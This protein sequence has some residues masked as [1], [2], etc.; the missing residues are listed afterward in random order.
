MIE[1]I[2]DFRAVSSPFF[3]HLETAKLTALIGRN[4][5]AINIAQ[6]TTATEF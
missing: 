5:G 2:R 4:N 6:I 1:P 3:T